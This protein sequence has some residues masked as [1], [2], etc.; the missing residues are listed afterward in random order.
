MNCKYYYCDCIR[1]LSYA[2]ASPHVGQLL[3]YHNICGLTYI[4]L[5]DKNLPI[6]TLSF[7]PVLIIIY[8]MYT[9][10]TFWTDF[11]SQNALLSKGR[12]VS[13]IQTLNGPYKALL[14]IN[15]ILEIHTKIKLG[16]NWAVAYYVQ[17]WQQGLVSS[18][19]EML[20]MH[21]HV[22]AVIDHH[23]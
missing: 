21:L 10:N 18:P 23:G 16:E 6:I 14:Y 2:H 12:N 19:C 5:E 3:T 11:Y 8:L 1:I 7:F 9:I 13:F 17:L 22:D 20:S 4:K 15:C